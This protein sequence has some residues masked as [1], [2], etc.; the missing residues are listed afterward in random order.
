MGVD[1]HLKIKSVKQKKYKT[2][3]LLISEDE[4]SP[5]KTEK[6]LLPLCLGFRNNDNSQQKIMILAALQSV[7]D[8]NLT[9][10]L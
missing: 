3:L 9:F 7:S 4:S 6:L 5:W 1:Y 8:Y 2:V 10:Y